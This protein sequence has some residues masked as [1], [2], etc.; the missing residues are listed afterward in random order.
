MTVVQTRSEPANHGSSVAYL[1][2]P[3]SYSHQATTSLFPGKEWSLVPTATIKGVFDMVQSGNAA[4]G[5]IP[6][7]NSTHGVV[8]FTLDSL[9]DRAGEFAD[10]SVCGEV[11]LDV[12]HFLLG[13]RDPTADDPN[14][15]AHIRHVYS[16]PQA[17][18]QTQ[19]FTSTRLAHAE[20]VD[21][22]ST[23]RGAEMAAADA[24][25]TSAAV[26]S[27]MAA[28]ATGLDIL[29]RS[30]QDRGDN[31][32]RFLVLRRGRPSVARQ[33]ASFAVAAAA[34]TK[35]LVSFTVP[36]RCPGALAEVLQ[37]FQRHGLDL[38]SINSLPSLIQPFQYLFFVEFEAADR[39]ESSIAVVLEDVARVAQ[40]SRWLGS[41]GSKR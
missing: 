7:E 22:S 4:Y 41:W 40:S 28:A 16:H 26:A 10:V 25:R 15:L 39:A 14:S 19:G 34:A 27:E 33:D 2:P 32:T 18:G 17:F 38:T 24:S 8:T 3:A 30:I 31:T 9:G 36:H 12:Q 21:V 1:G 20:L 35:S 11:Y 37:C 23:S 29:A 13:R 6:F 5:V